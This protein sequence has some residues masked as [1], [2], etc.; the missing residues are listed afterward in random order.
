MKSHL[1]LNC[2]HLSYYLL[3][4]MYISKINIH[5]Y[6]YVYLQA[7]GLPKE[8]IKDIKQ[9]RRTMKNRDYAKQE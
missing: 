7:K 8:V 1:T 6:V 4:E 9:R 2:P 5:L 3:F